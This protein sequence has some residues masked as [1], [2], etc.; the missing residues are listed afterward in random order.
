MHCE[1]LTVRPGDLG[2]TTGDLGS[3]QP[4]ALDILQIIGIVDFICSVERLIESDVESLDLVGI[5]CRNRS[6]QYCAYRVNE[7]QPGSDDKSGDNRAHHSGTFYYRPTDGP[8]ATREAADDGTKHDAR[9]N[10]GDVSDQ[11]I[12]VT[13]AADEGD[14]RLR[15]F[16]GRNEHNADSHGKEQPSRRKDSKYSKRYKK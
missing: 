14:D 11:V 5:G 4:L 1:L 12:A 13:Q 3:D 10:P 16:H 7:R 9:E 6:G 15:G 2:K 8:G